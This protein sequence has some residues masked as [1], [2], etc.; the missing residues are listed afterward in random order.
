MKQ[1]SISKRKKF[2]I[3]F[4]G[5]S[6][7]TSIVYG[8]ATKGY[9]LDLVILLLIFSLLTILG[10]VSYFINL[11]RP[12]LVFN[13]IGISGFSVGSKVIPWTH[14]RSISL[15]KQGIRLFQQKYLKVAITSQMDVRIYLS[16]LNDNA[17]NIY[18]SACENQ[19]A[20]GAIVS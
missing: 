12:I 15:H 4:I 5:I 9:S 11:F 16:Y 20:Y 2:P 7:T 3:L 10:G 8:L 14:I 1:Y 18:N 6:I 17:E 13:A 19:K